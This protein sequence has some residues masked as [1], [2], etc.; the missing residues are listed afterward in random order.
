MEESHTRAHAEGSGNDRKAAEAY[1]ISV[2]TV[3]GRDSPPNASHHQGSGI[4][5]TRALSPLGDVK[6]VSEG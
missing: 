1:I 6:A 3:S 5:E 2:Q 4:I